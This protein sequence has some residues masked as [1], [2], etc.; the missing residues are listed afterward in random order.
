MACGG[1]HNK[2]NVKK[3]RAAGIRKANAGDWLKTYG[4]ALAKS[5]LGT[6]DGVTGVLGIDT[7]LQNIVKDPIDSSLVFTKKGKNFGDMSN[8]I[9]NTAGTVGEVFGN[10]GAKVGLAALGVPPTDKTTSLLPGQIKDIKEI[11]P[12]YMFE[13]K[14]FNPANINTKLTPP[15]QFPNK[16]EPFDNMFEKT[17]FDFQTGGMTNKVVPT[18]GGLLKRLSSTA[19]VAKGNTHDNG[20]IM[21]DDETEVENNEGVHNIDGQSVISSDVLKNKETENSFAKDMTKYEKE[22]GNYE[23]KLLKE[24]E[25]TLGRDNYNTLLYKKRI[26]Q[27]EDTIKELYE[28]QEELA[29][30]MGLRDEQGNPNQTSQ[31]VVGDEQG[32]KELQNQ[33]EN[34][35]NINPQQQQKVPINQRF[36]GIQIN[37]KNKGKFT[38]KANKRGKGVQEFANDVL[39][40]KD[41]YSV[42]TVR[43]ANF[44]KNSTKFKHIVGGDYD[45]DKQL[46]GY[47]DNSPYKGSKYIDI[48]GDKDGVNIT[49]KG[50]SNPLIAKPDVGNSII[51]QPEKDYYFPN[52]KK[53]REIPL[54]RSIG[55]FRKIV[56]QIP[57]ETIGI[58]AANIN[59]AMAKRMPPKAEPPPINPYP[60]AITLANKEYQRNV[61]DAVAKS[62]ED[63]ANIMNKAVYSG[64]ANNPA[65][66]A[67][68]TAANKGYN[69]FADK[70]L[71]N[72]NNIN[73]SFLQEDLKKKEADAIYRNMKYMNLANFENDRTQIRNDM[74]AKLASNMQEM[75]NNDS[76]IKYLGRMPVNQNKSAKEIL[77]GLMSIGL[78]DDNK[79]TT[80]KTGGKISKKRFL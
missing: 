32:I 54:K 25:K 75:N 78:L 46:L 28:K 27:I 72:K 16:R 42:E 2:K 71:Q 76:L 7:N 66:T 74:W 33:V 57:F 49:M 73:L 14:P 40:N 53:V 37:P 5:A 31:D 69:E 59:N 11:D 3:Y 21:L 56:N 62:R 67:Y 51:M 18:E 4:S 43:Q 77:D 34:Q 38:A 36:G 41:R 29:T 48:V 8:K 60:N 39:D 44:A 79:S 10:I 17:N 9:V 13:Q 52:A 55:G 45:R 20:G 23:E 1:S 68:L 12:M 24:Y 15:N 70:G 26:K 22:K 30:K 65:F 61:A 19:V 58:T 35:G 63:L 80:N 47:K 64:N 50:V 6:I